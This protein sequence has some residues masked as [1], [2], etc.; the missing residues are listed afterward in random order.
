MNKEEQ[1]RLD[2]MLLTEIGEEIRAAREAK[3]WT[4][5]RLS[6]MASVQITQLRR[7]EG[8]EIDMRATTYRRIQKALL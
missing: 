5:Y 2:K 7:I 6:K 1:Q 4:L 8:G 3:S